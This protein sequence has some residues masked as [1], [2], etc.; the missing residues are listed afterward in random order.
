MTAAAAAHSSAVKAWC[1]EDAAGR[2]K[3]EED[4]E[5]SGGL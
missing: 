3:L 4:R 2:E 5:V 1:S